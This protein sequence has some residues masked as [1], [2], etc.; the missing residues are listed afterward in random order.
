MNN[1]LLRV[2]Q[3]S[4]AF[5]APV[6]KSVSLTVA[7]GEVVALTGENGAGKS[8]LA[9]I[10]A[11]IAAPDAGELFLD[12]APYAPVSRVAAERAGVRMV[13]QELGLVET[14]SI[15]ENL[16]LGRLPSRAG[17]IRYA[18][19]A[20]IAR[21]QLERVGL[22][23]IDPSQS[24]SELGIGQQQ[25]VEIARALL[26]HVRL[27]ILDE[28][29]AMLTAPE[30]ERLFEQVTQLKQSGVGVIYIS[31]RLDEVRQLTDRIIVLRD[32]ELVADRPTSGMT[33]DEIVNAMIGRE[34]AVER[35][36]PDRAADR[37]LLRVEGI[38]CVNRVRNVSLRLHA[39]EIVGIAGLVGAG[40]TELL[41]AI[42]GADEK[43]AGEIYLDGA[44]SPIRITSPVDAVRHGI[45][46]LTEDRK[47]QGLLLTQSLMTNVTL[48]HLLAVSREGWI[49][50]GQEKTTAVR[51]MQQLRIRARDAEQSVNEL[52]GGN[53]Q[54]VLLARWLHRDCRILLLDEPTRGIDIGARDDIYAMLDTLA[55]AGKA[56]LVVSSDLRE[57]MEVCDRIAVMSAGSIVR[58][59]K[60]GE[61]SE[62]ALLGAAFAAYRSG[63]GSTEGVTSA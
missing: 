47:T 2:S 43:N 23:D 22:Q 34:R 8:T 14:L 21:R 18:E 10:V 54:K 58:V 36:R 50:P 15:A 5:A 55:S 37:E 60:R 25:L 6:L 1:A 41:R 16:Q 27:L 4:K 29:T 45:G 52:S 40:R 19:M 33:H 31:H 12:G 61:W 53:Q 13:L 44:T 32:G 7:A 17:F 62:E 59:F 24:V 38:S 56:L 20:D 9:R 48:S 28:P 57:L 35:D 3:V 11:G 30:V 26:G 51:W 63:S 39:G 49:R 46:L 42:F